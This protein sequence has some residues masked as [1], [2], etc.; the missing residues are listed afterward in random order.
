M[1]QSS[2][3]YLVPVGS[4]DVRMFQ[5]LQT[6]GWQVRL[7]LGWYPF[8]RCWVAETSTWVDS[9]CLKSGEVQAVTVQKRKSRENFYGKRFLATSACEFFSAGPGAW[10]CDCRYLRFGSLSLSFGLF[11]FPGFR[12]A[13]YVS[14]CNHWAKLVLFRVVKLGRTPSLAEGRVCSAGAWAGRSI[15]G[16]S[17]EMITPPSTPSLPASEWRLETE[18]TR[19][20][21]HGVKENP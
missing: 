16:R 11:Q 14:S 1:L 3:C 21:R 7:C 5:I 13:D 18:N 15:A 9:S 10:L 6:N 2:F 8:K 4:V 12:K 20:T 19:K 17:R